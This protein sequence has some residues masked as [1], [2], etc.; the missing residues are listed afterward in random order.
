MRRNWFHTSYLIV[1]VAMLLAGS[2]LQ[3]SLLG[4][5]AG[6]ED[7]SILATGAFMSAY[8]AGYLLGS[9]YCVTLIYRVGHIRTFAALAALASAMPLLHGLFVDPYLWI[10]L[11]AVSGLCFAGL[12]TV[13]E[14]WINGRANNLNRGTWLAVYMIVSLMSL[15]A[16]QQLLQ[17]AS[18]TQPGLFVLS[19]LLASIAVVPVALTQSTPPS[20][21]K[22]GTLPL[23]LLFKISPL[24][25]TASFAAGLATGPFWS[26]AALMAHEIGFSI[27]MVAHLMTTTILGGMALQ[28][29]IG[30]LSD[31]FDRRKIIVAV[32]LSVAGVSALIAALAQEANLL[33]F[34]LSFAFG[35]CAFSLYSL[36]VAHTNDFMKEN[37]LIAA[38]GG[39]LFAYGLGAFVG[40]F[41]AS[42]VIALAG[43]RGLFVHI[44]AVAIGLAIFG[45]ARVFARP[46]VPNEAQE[47]FVAVPN[48][49]PVAEGL[50]PRIEPD[51]RHRDTAHVQQVHGDGM[52][53]VG[54]STHHSQST[55]PSGDRP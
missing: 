55:P 47:K 36:S 22:E 33:L 40:P 45:L 34:P 15:A 10:P 5:R 13:M 53:P 43:P 38:S 18:P 26:L 35:G 23:R 21:P 52:S 44:G 3:F 4:L 25:L 14:S 37:D 41:I 11:R 19:A 16:A 6:I 32:S 17:L 27:S 24:G 28:W 31:R 51:G 2:G 48:T 30:R 1:G 42:E 9:K 54:E 20:V 8:Y 12:L 49:T 46:P 39:L 50:D 7:F 29:P